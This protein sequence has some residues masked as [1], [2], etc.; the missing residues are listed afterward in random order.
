MQINYGK[1]VRDHTCINQELT[2][3][4]RDD[5][6]SEKLLYNKTSK[7]ITYV[8]LNFLFSFP[9]ERFPLEEIHG[10]L[11]PSEQEAEI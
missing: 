3:N 7:C 6:G 4:W 1:V 5:L 2:Q 11:R 9:I 10:W 8:V